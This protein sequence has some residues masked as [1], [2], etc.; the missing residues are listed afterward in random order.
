MTGRWRRAGAVL[1]VGFVVGAAPPAAGGPHG[2]ITPGGWT[3]PATQ[4]RS[5]DRV[6]PGGSREP[7]S[8]GRDVPVLLVPGWGDDSDVL[9]PL[10]ESFVEAGWDEDHVLPVSFR[11]PVGS[12]R[13]H[14]RELA[15]MVMKLKRRSDAE[16]V[17]V[18]AHSMGGLATRYY[19]LNGGAGD[20]RRVVFL[21]TPHEGTLSAYL[22]WGDGAREMQP[23][24]VFLLGL[25]RA[26]AVPSG[27]RAIT[28]RTP[29]DLHVLPP[30]SAT[31]PGLPNLEVCCPTHEGLLDDPATFELIERFLKGPS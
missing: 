29:L 30:E 1:L 6:A 13:E 18:V 11:D 3:A 28:I 16:R 10:R 25:R 20:V 7:L 5:P 14:A 2:S 21:A 19:L 27:V 17:D 26:R 22:V 4:G 24:S 12:N 9:D 23:G 31:V 8:R 15:H